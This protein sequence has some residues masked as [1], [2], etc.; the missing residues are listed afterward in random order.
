[1]PAEVQAQ[2]PLNPDFNRNSRDFGRVGMRSEKDSTPCLIS[3]RRGAS[4]PKKRYF[5]PLKHPLQN[6]EKRYSH[7]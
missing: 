4:L 6:T 1:M 5:P 7:W 3:R 2:F